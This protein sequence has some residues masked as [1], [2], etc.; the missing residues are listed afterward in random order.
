MNPQEMLQSAFAYM[1]PARLL[2]GL[3]SADAARRIPGT[4]HTIVELVAHLVF[5]QNWFS[6]VS[7]GG[8]FRWPP[9][10]PRLACRR[11]RGLGSAAG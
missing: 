3:T 2:E 9:A 8:R 7:P 6:S 10:P 1:P 5:W 4:L 11:C